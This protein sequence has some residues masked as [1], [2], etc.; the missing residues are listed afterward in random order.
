MA[1]GNAVTIAEFGDEQQAQQ[2]AA[3]IGKTRGWQQ[4]DA[5]GGRQAWKGRIPQDYSLDLGYVTVFATGRLVV[6]SS[7]P[8]GATQQLIN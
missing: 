5:V 3:A 4:A 6:M 7:L 2:A 1:Y 8:D